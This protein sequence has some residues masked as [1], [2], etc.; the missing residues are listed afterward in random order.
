M[1]L[2]HPGDMDLNPKGGSYRLQA[3]VGPA[4]VNGLRA[5][6]SGVRPI[7]FPV[8]GALR[9][10]LL[11]GHRA[12]RE[13][14]LQWQ[15]WRAR[16]AAGA[17][18]AGGGGRTRRR[19]RCDSAAWLSVSVLHN[20]YVITLLACLGVWAGV[21]CLDRGLFQKVHSTLGGGGVYM[22]VCVSVKFSHV[23][24]GWT[25]HPASGC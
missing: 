11:H 18:A 17:G 14:D 9:A 24:R 3:S 6:P 15:R 5:S 25:A 21:L 7:P 2:D 8:A 22:H 12:A 4:E 10:V 20:S 23:A 1:P 13:A 19:C 16:G